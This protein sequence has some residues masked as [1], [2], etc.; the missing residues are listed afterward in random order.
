MPIKSYK[1]SDVSISSALGVN[2]CAPSFIARAPLP[3]P[4]CLLPTMG[5][6][7]ATL[8]GLGGTPV[9]KQHQENDTET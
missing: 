1:Y 5:L 6:L 8:G 2:F 4:A 9:D 3:L 7:A